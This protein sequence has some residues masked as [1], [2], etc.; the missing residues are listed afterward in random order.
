MITIRLANERGCD[1]S[2]EWG[3]RTARNALT[4]SQGVQKLPVGEFELRFHLVPHDERVPVLYL[5]AYK[6]QQ[7]RKKV[8]WVKTVGFSMKL[9]HRK[10]RVMQFAPAH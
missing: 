9:I 4:L 6:K 1:N 5:T 7:A 3:F 2:R 8:Q 10:S